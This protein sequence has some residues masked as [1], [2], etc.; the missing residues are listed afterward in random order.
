MTAIK[1][2]ITFITD[3]QENSFTREI[4]LPIPPTDSGMYLM[5]AQTFCEIEKEILFADFHE[6]LADPSL[7]SVYENRSIT[8]ESVTAGQMEA[9]SNMQQVWCEITNTLIAARY[10]LAQSRGCKEVEVSLPNPR[11]GYP[12]SD[13][14]NMHISRMNAFD[15]AVYRLAKIEDLFLLLL[16]VSF[17]CSLAE[18]N[19][20]DEDWQKRVSWKSIREGLKRRNPAIVSNKYLNGLPDE[21]YKS[22]LTVFNKFKNP[23]EVNEI[24]NYRHA[25]TH[26][27][28]PAVD[29]HGFNGVL[30]YVKPEDRS[31]KP[32]SG[33]LARTYK[34]DHE[35]LTLYAKAVKVYE[36]YVQVLKELK[37]VR[38]F[39]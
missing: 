9:D 22:I 6:Q 3:G 36:H 20:D 14:L 17:G 32:V 15:A 30:K 33:L 39:A 16:F 31:G 18:V 26:R 5:A 24:V 8:F 12:T 34:L 1:A 4:N 25:T 21:D 11:P 10:L 19:M 23:L 27:I 35:F 38:Q 37:K 29:Y 28:P 13:V 7:L 2:T